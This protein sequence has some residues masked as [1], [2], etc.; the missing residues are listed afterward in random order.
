MSR[1]IARYLAVLAL[2]AV[3]AIAQS[4]T[5]CLGAPSCSLNPTVSL[6][7][8]KVVRLALTGSTI[9]LD[10]PT[11][12]TD[13]LAGQSVTTTFTGVSVRANHSWTIN[14]STAAANW[15]YVGS[16]G[17]VR[18]ASTLEFQPN[19]AGGFTAISNT[20][21]MVRSGALTNG[22]AANLCLATV[23]PA[24]Y[25]STANRPGTYTLAITLT[26]AAD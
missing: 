21:T 4:Q 15:T 22:S 2:L 9:T 26:L 25:S 11:W 23:F 7:I 16:E 12:T 19:C 6:T 20:P 17:G 3:P 10:T 24:D 8:P 1:S 18:A 14:I 13:S 5:L